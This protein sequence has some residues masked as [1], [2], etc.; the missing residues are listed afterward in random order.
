MVSSANGE[1]PNGPHKHH[2]LIASMCEVPSILRLNY[3]L[4]WIKFR[5]HCLAIVRTWWIDCLA[6]A[7]A[8]LMGNA[9]LLNWFWLPITTWI[10][11][12]QLLTHRVY[13][14]NCV[15]PNGNGYV[16]Q[17]NAQLISMLWCVWPARALLSCPAHKRR[18]KHLQQLALIKCDMCM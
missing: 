14:S 15:A 1:R 16:C 7:S 13:H 12:E 3:S 4:H 9:K 18:C 2:A 17:D 6:S 8:K 5:C 11:A 10:M